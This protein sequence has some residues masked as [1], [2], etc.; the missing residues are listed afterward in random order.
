MNIPSERIKTLAIQCGFD[1]CGISPVTI[2]SGAKNFYSN[3]I[4]S[5]FNAGM[6]YLEEGQNNRFNPRNLLPEAKSVISVISSYHHSRKLDGKYRISHYAQGKD[7][8]IV[9][10]QKLELLKE[11]IIK[12]FPF[13]VSIPFCDTSSVLERYFAAQAGLG[14]IGKNRCLINHKYG[15]WVFIAGMICNVE[16]DYDEASELS[17]A[18]CDDCL[19][20]CP[21]KA[22]SEHGLD[23][24]KCISYHTIENKNEI[25][26]NVRAQITNQLFGCDICQN[27]CPINKHANVSTCEAFKLLPQIEEIN[28]EELQQMSNR[29]FSRK[30]KNTSLLR[31]GRKKII[32]NFDTL[33][34]RN[35][36]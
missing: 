13:F 4:L 3:W 31:S 28:Y 26:E 16:T 15:S 6:Q 19:R 7:Y 10:K 21:T 17:C 14:F 9:M 2:S 24:R 35:K 12:E 34:T 23:A 36:Q 20:S 29:E 18:D 30:F 1:D 8:H 5:G 27:V 11:E 32:S 33:I 25:P 22:L